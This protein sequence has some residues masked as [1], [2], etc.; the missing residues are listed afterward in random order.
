MSELQDQIGR[1]GASIKWVEPENLHFTLKFLG[2]T[3]QAAVAQLAQVASEVAARHEPFVVELRGAGAFPRPAQARAIWVGCGSGAE[4]MTGLATDLEGALTDAGLAPK[5]KRSL[6][7]HLT[8]GRNKGRHRGMELAQAIEEAKSAQM[9]WMQV[10][11]F[12]LVRSQLTSQGPVYTDAA[13][14][15][16]ENG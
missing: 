7:A 12:A 2:E 10:S 14:F 15:P 5:E 13:Q 8:I 11:G 9:G 1:A 4:A 6:S 3:P 16:L